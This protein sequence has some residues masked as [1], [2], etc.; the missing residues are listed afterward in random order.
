MSPATM[1]ASW[2]RTGGSLD[3]GELHPTRPQVP[4]QPTWAEGR[5]HTFFHPQAQVTVPRQRVPVREWFT[6]GMPSLA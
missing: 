5:W 2:A 6:G 1:L 3:T 4:R